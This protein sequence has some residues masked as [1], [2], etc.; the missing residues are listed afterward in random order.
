MPGG[1]RLR[2]GRKA[3]RIDPAELAKLCVPQCTDLELAAWFGVS[4]RTIER[5]RKRPAFAEAI[6]KGKAKVRLSLR[7]SL[8][9]LAV[10]GNPAANI[11]LAKNLLGYTDLLRNEHTGPDNGTIRNSITV[12]FVKPGE[13]DAVESDM[14]RGG[15]KQ[16]PA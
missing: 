7:R 16:R 2:A 14:G 15:G 3:I 10:K 4:V 12:R 5:R 13:K 6:E 11:F 1:A 8:W 9:A